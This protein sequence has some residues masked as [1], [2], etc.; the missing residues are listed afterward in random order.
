[1]R[2]GAA[3]EATRGNTSAPGEAGAGGAVDAAGDAPFGIGDSTAGVG[4]GVDA[5]PEAVGGVLTA[6]ADEAP[7]CETSEILI[8][9]PD[10]GAESA[11]A[12][13]SVVSNALTKSLSG[14]ITRRSKLAAE[15]RRCAELVSNACMPSRRESEME[16]QIL[17]C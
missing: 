13:G 6:S 15:A 8:A 4:T 3:S 1:M 16:I 17:K 2:F 14:G 12:G 9:V 10:S 7:G 5:L 11:G